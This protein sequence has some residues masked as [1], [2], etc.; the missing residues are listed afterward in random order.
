M[1]DSRPVRVAAVPTVAVLLVGIVI[2]LQIA[3]PI[4]GPDLQDRLTVV[5]VW[6]AAAAAVGPAAQV[7]RGPVT[8]LLVV[9]A[10]GFV[11]EVVGVHTGMPFGDY[12]YTAQLGPQLW[13]VPVVIAPAWMMISWPAALAARRLVSGP[14][15]RVVVGAW[16]L[17]SWDLF[18][19]PQMVDAG[20]W[21]WADPTPH[22]P[23]VA[24]V[25][26]SNLA[27]WLAVSLLVSAVLQ[28][29]CARVGSIA[30]RPMIFFYLWT[31]ASSVLG[32]TVFLGLPAAAC[33]GA[34]GMGVVAIPL[35]VRT[36]R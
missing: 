3:Y 17:A 34:L 20:R 32:L 7:G 8:A 19:D 27:G 4:A 23:G 11:A 25:P 21:R 1:L 15:A 24:A 9:G 35:A 6:L 33:W 18:L 30:D 28:H 5:I 36:W 29:A 22:L 13:D 31:Y 16:A 12:G 10:L 2:A 14:L 26:L